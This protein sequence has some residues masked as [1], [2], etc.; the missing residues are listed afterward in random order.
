MINVFLNQRIGKRLLQ[1]ILKEKRAQYGEKIV[2]ALGRQL[3][4][5]FGRG[6]LKKS[7]WHMI[8][9]TEVS[10]KQKIVHALSAQF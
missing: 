7:L 10:P 5:E 9:F 6:F 4:T 8:R 1:D 2:S 3:E